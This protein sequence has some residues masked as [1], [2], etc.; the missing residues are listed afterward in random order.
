VKCTQSSA[1][2]LGVVSPISQDAIG[3][4]ARP[5]TQALQRR[6]G[7]E[8]RQ[9]LGGVVAIRAS[10]FNC[11]WNATPIT[12]H[13][14]LAARLARSVGFAP[15]CGPQKLLAQN[16]YQQLH[17]TSRSGHNERANSATRSESS[18][19]FRPCCQSRKPRQH[20]MP[21]PQPSCFGS[22]R[23]GIPLRSTNRIPVRQARS[24]TRGRPPCGFGAEA[25]RSGP[26]K[27]HRASETSSAAITIPPSREARR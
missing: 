2:F 19:K 26:I 21:E 6:N 15:V 24:D 8:Q 12:D 1:D 22:I 7:I 16:N 3:A 17:G 23:H 20:V 10:Q 11:Q 9:R 25:G 13:M 5:T 27:L 14:A 4:T 18:P